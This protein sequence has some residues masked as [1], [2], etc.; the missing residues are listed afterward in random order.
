MSDSGTLP[1][2][3]AEPSKVDEVGAGEVI[4]DLLAPTQREEEETQQGVV[5]PTREDEKGPPI[6]PEV[7]KEVPYYEMKVIITTPQYR[8]VPRGGFLISNSAKRVASLLL[9]DPEPSP[10]F[11]FRDKVP[12]P[13]KSDFLL[14]LSSI[15]RRGPA[16]HMLSLG[17]VTV[18]GRDLECVAALGELGCSYYQE[19]LLISVELW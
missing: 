12:D 18:L 14:L 7:L 2:N 3:S 16:I 17:E 4:L 15:R 11:S 13:S 10:V 19:F 1:R 8:G 5:T 9:T 6:P